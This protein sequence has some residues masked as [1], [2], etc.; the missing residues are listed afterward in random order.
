MK[1]LFYQVN[2][3][4]YFDQK[5][6]LAWAGQMG[7]VDPDQWD[8]GLPQADGREGWLQVG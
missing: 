2:A 8:A 6:F 1:R 7:L 5:A 4:I 3:R